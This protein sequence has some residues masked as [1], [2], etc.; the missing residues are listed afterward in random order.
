MIVNF[1]RATDMTLDDFFEF[2]QDLNGQPSA[3][4][5]SQQKEVNIPE[6]PVKE[7]STNE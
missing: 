4:A 1:V 7:E 3:S 2:M 5:V 6:S